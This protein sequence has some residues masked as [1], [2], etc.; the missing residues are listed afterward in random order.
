MIYRNKQNI[1]STTKPSK[2]L[3]LILKQNNYLTY[4]DDNKVTWTL[5]FNTA[6]DINEFVT[7]LSEKCK[8]Q[9]KKNVVTQQTKT[10]K[11]NE[12]IKSVMSDETDTK[13]DMFH[14]CSTNIES[15]S[16]STQSHQ[17]KS[18][19]TEQSMISSLHHI[20]KP[21]DSDTSDSSEAVLTK[22]A[23]ILS[24]VA[25]MGK[26]L[27]DNQSSEV[28]SDSSDFD[29]FSKTST[30]NEPSQKVTNK[31]GKVLK[32]SVQTSNEKAIS[33]S[34]DGQTS[35]I[36]YS[37]SSFQNK[38][39]VPFNQENSTMISTE[40]STD[41]LNMLLLGTYAFI[42]DFHCSFSQMLLGRCLKNLK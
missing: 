15:E 22:K 7:I 36:N 17:N 27:I 30:K 23:D 29:D 26:K 25:K 41:Q 16:L 6:E 40:I 24:R 11:S 38:V 4:T 9:V 37:S 34:V 42:I 14:N 5:N 2:N 8:C 3:E 10:V 31:K 20:Q 12:D 1:I 13:S 35:R 28:I 39:I 21:I 32:H 19:D 18:K 33:H